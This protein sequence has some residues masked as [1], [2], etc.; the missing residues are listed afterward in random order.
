MIYCLFFGYAISLRFA[1][2]QLFFFFFTPPAFAERHYACY[3]AADFAM[4]PRCLM[5]L[6]PPPRHASILLI[7]FAA[8]TPFSP[9]RHYAAAAIFAVLLLMLMTP[10]FR[11]R[12]MPLSPFSSLRCRCRDA[13]FSLL[14]FLVDAAIEMLM[15]IRFHYFSLSF[16][17]RFADAY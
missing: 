2:A 1:A 12:L 17:F 5:P 15:M 14:I 16:R 9:C 13:L 11:R 8:I 7:A 6:T 10:L 3:F 4:P